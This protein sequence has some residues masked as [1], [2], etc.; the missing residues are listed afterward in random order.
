RPSF[1]CFALALAFAPACK[2]AEAHTHNL[3]E[4]HEDNGRHKRTAAL[5]GDAEYAF[6]QIFASLV[7]STSFEPS[8]KAPKKVEDPL[9]ACVENL[10]ALS[11]FEPETE[12]AS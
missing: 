5:M 7:R 12:N 8:P 10:I 9:E 4:L 11:E 2:V 6:Q 1:A 3:S